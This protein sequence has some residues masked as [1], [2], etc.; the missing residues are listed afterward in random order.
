MRIVFGIVMCEFCGYVELL[1]LGFILINLF[2]RLNYCK[3]GVILFFRFEDSKKLDCRE[4]IGK[5][6]KVWIF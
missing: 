5:K 6:L 1:S 4:Y 3:Y 2:V